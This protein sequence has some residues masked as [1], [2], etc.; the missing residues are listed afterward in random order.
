MRSRH[1]IRWWRGA[2]LTAFLAITSVACMVN[3]NATNAIESCMNEKLSIKYFDSMV[4]RAKKSTETLPILI[5]VQDC[6]GKP[7]L[8]DRL[9]KLWKL[10]EK[11][12]TNK[13]P[14]AFADPLFRLQFAQQYAFEIATLSGRS[15]RLHEIQ[16]YVR[17]FW[18]SP[19]PLHQM[20]SL[21]FHVRL[22]E[23]D[24]EE[25]YEIA[26][27]NESMAVV[28]MTSLAASMGPKAK[29]RIKSILEK[30]PRI[31]STKSIKDYLDQQLE[32]FPA[33]ELAFVEG[34][35]AKPRTS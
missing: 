3:A 26:M 2:A 1:D 24:I 29:P 16:Q 28:V 23:C 15:Q 30:W 19:D 8:V 20:N 34:R 22:N 17:S 4:N 5:W 35:C 12:P 10:G 31:S 13:H 14:N 25:I 21:R 11:S 18:S 6:S 9:D 27:N 33:K 32:Y 7:T